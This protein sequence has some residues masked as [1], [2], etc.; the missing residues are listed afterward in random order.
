L[1]VS[2]TRIATVK[3][4]LGKGETSFTPAPRGRPSKKKREV[5]WTF[6]QEA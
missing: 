6:S 5:N 1:R 4:M 3:K 2:M